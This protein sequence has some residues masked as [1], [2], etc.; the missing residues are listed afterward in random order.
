MTMYLS[1]HSLCA[2]VLMMLSAEQQS[3]LSPNSC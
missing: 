3:W 1:K 2:A